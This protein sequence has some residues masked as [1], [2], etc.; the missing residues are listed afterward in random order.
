V[1]LEG[2]GKLKKFN[3]LIGTRTHDLPA[4]SIVPTTCLPSEIMLSST[5]PVLTGK[6]YCSP[7]AS[8]KTVNEHLKRI[9]GLYQGTT[10]AS[11]WRRLPFY[12]STDSR[13]H[14]QN[15]NQISHQHKTTMLLH[16]NPISECKLQR[17]I[18]TPV[19]IIPRFKRK[20]LKKKH[21]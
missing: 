17:D 6:H 2:L 19:G 1:Q 18:S 21:M 11:V 5:C 14:Y 3:N 10:S 8:W 9:A 7:S 4:C 16:T 13:K 15:F 20:G 12:L